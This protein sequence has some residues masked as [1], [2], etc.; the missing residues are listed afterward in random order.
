MKPIM[1]FSIILMTAIILASSFGL[2]IMPIEPLYQLTREQSATALYV[3][4]AASQTW[5]QIAMILRPMSRII[6][7]VFFFAILMLMFFWGWALYQNLLKDKFEQKAFNSVWGATKAVFWAG[8]IV[9]ILM[10]TPGYYRGVS[11]IGDS[12]SWVL[13][14]LNSPG[15]IPVHSDAVK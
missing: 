4:P 8:A 7:M 13:C 12:R 3:C 1:L 15:A 6:S 11:V 5:D 2:H 9:L 10:W 14:E